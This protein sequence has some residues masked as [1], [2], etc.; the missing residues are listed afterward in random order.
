VSATTTTTTSAA[1]TMAAPA[2]ERGWLARWERLWF[3][4]ASLVRLAVFRI[5]ILVAAFDGVWV[6][7]KAVFQRVAALDPVFLRRTFHP[8]YA[9]ELLGL[10]PPG[11][12]AA[13]VVWSALLAALA[14]GIL[15]LFT[16]VACGVAALL[17]CYWIGSEYSFGK[18]HHTCVALAFALLALPFAPVGAR[19]SL[20]SLGRRW[21]AARAGDA[22]SAPERAEWAAFPL[23]LTQ[24]T[25]ALGYFFAA[26]TKLGK[27]GAGWAN[28]Y[29]LMGILV[30][31]ESA[32][33]PFLMRHREW[34]A[35]MS[36]GLLL[37]QLGFPLIF[38]GAWAR[39]VFVPLA[40]LFHLLAMQTMSTG[41]FLTLW[42]ALAAFVAL[43]R[44]PAFLRSTVGAGPAWRR[45][46]LALVLA[47]LAYETAAL[48]LEKKPAWFVWALVPLAYAALLWSLPRFLPALEVVFDPRERSARVAAAWIAACDWAGRIELRPVSGAGAGLLVGGVALD[49][50]HARR[51]VLVRLPLA[52]L[53]APF[54]WRAFG[55]RARARTSPG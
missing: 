32:W 49:A 52:P 14:L 5:V 43:E 54:V 33:S 18:P 9:F 55:A 42:L 35:L 10:G 20:D 36:V 8:I 47:A 45:L 53:V 3:G 24:L 19:L 28:G 13:T 1:A 7:R 46:A 15:G 41:P 26:A 38:L 29:T 44:V 27:S 16:R 21:R 2:H 37:V 12:V 40:I 39:W 30:E 25:I 48:Y 4:E 50:T 22:W 11:P 51:S 31:Y 23:V 6:V 34:L 17:T